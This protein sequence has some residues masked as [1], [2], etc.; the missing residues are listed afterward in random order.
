MLAAPAPALDV[1]PHV[2]CC[3]VYEDQVS[4]FLSFFFEREV[5]SL[6][7]LDRVLVFE[8]RQRHGAHFLIP[9]PGFAVVVSKLKVAD[10]YLVLVA[11][12]VGPFSLSL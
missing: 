5:G 7:Q 11:Q 10:V 3:A 8:L 6:P 1:G 2:D 12:K 9:Q 4:F